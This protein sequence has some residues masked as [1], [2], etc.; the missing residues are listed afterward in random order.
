MA[1]LTNKWY[2]KS[3]KWIK[4]IRDTEKK[5]KK[6]APRPLMLQHLEKTK[7][8]KCFRSQEVKSFREEVVSH[9]ECW[10]EVKLN[11]D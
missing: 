8:I 10:K 7:R 1:I 11:V 6:T 9:I 4:S 3:C 2:L 5:I